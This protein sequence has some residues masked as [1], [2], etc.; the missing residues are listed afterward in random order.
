MNESWK[1]AFACYLDRRV[2]VILLLGFSAG[3]PL[4][5][6][7][8]SLSLWLREAGVE[9]QTVTMFSWAALAYSFKFVWAPLIDSLPV[10]KLT[11][12]L[13]RRRAWL[14]IAQIMVIIAIFFMAL[15]NPSE[16]GSLLTMAVCAVLLGFSSATQDIAIDAYRIEVADIEM[17]SALA[18]SYTAGYRIG[19]IFSGAGALYLAAFFGAGDDYNYAAWRSTYMIMG[20]FML[21]GVFTTLFMS[22]SKNNL[23]VIRQPS[24]Y[25][26]LT[27]VFAFL[28]VAFVI[29]FWSSGK[30]LPSTTSVFLNFILEI[31]RI[32]F[33]VGCAAATGFSAV[34]LKLVSRDVF[35]KMWVEPV[36]DFFHRYGKK[37]LLILALIGLYRISDIVAGVITNVFYQDLGFTL[38]E[39]ANAVKSFGV[40]MMILGSVVGGALAT[41]FNIMKMLFLGGLLACLTNLLFVV[42][43]YKGNDV[44]FFYVAVTMDNLAAG[45]ASA[46]FIAYLSSLVNVRFTA[47]QYAIF[48]SLMTLLPKVLG[49]YSG[50]IVD[51]TSYPVFFVITFLI[52]IPVLILI[53]FVAKIIPLKDVG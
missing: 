40:V 21:V 37:S 12:L 16:E 47:V 11:R 14:L 6:I 18:A 7:F 20:I 30:V 10:P 36:Y 19:M 48:S 52:G 23:S 33:A 4:L 38:K 29:T 44:L 24:D 46:V 31:L 1:A 41:R 5:L 45:L 13:G 32:F 42:L 51:A 53:Y 43:A 49:G 35:F 26:R 28:V 9:R 25:L 34:Y 27:M 3:L 15:T 50:S 8:S 2:L 39:I 17:Q 22:E